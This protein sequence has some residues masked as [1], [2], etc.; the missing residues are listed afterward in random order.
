MVKVF[1]DSQVPIGEQHPEPE[2]CQSCFWMVVMVVAGGVSR[3]R[4]L[5][6]GI[7][8]E[9]GRLKIRT[10]TIYHRYVSPEVR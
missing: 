9:R 8:S 4:E 10:Q 1:K 3:R 7:S 2:W 5:G 6:G